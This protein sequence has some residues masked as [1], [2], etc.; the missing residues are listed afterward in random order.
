MINPNVGGTEDGNPITVAFRPQSIV[1]N[2]IPNHSTVAGNNVMNP[3]AMDDD[4]LDELNSNTSSTSNMDIGS[5]TINGFVAAYDEFLVE[6]DNHTMGKD[7]PK[8]YL[9]DNCMA[10]GSTF[11]VNHVIVRRI[12][13]NVDL[14]GLSTGCSVAKAKDAFG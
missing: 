7:D 1:I 4:I 13:D 12:I 14:A 11:G 8:G 9:L 5:S 3:E 2:G 6:S 10:K